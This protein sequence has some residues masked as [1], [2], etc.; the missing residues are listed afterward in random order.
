M[1]TNQP[2]GVREGATE[3]VVP[4]GFCTKGPGKSTGEVFYNRQM[5]FSR[6]ISILF[7]RMVFRPQWR[8]LDGLAATGAR[9]LRLANECDGNFQVHLNDRS[10]RA[11]ERIQGNAKLNHLDDI[12]VHNRDLRALLAEEGFDYIDVDPFGTPVPFVDAAVQSV[13]DRGVLA[14]T[15][16]DTAPLCGTYPRTCAR[17]YGAVSARAPFSNETGL[18]ILIGY[19]A[20]EAARY[21]RGCEPLLC[22]HADHYFRCHLRIRNGARRADSALESIGYAFH[23]PASLARG[24]SIQTPK[25][26]SLAVA[27]PLWTGE[28]HCREVLDRMSPDDA[29]GT[30]SRCKKA[31]GL[32]RG[33]VAAP[34][35]YYRVDEL[36]QHTKRQ[37]P[38][39]A[40]L[41]D[42]LCSKGAVAA[43]TH[44]D[45]KGLKT[46]LPAEELL[47]LFK[48]IVSD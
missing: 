14:I 46:D 40:R 6:D 35:L 11:A 44:F 4:A 19:I 27:G 23:D 33:E 29:L 5:E 3:L 25:D 7:A 24:V 17:R 34:A 39:M 31:I 45:P 30:H 47:R 42:E 15:A 48:D 1:R 21:D 8:V 28:L 20:R 18:R 38:K 10:E 16:T 32:W 22:F 9:G 13:R 12:V 2:V 26:A 36:A 43:Q 37:P 41:V